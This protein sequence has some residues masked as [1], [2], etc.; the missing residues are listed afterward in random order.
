VISLLSVSFSLG[1]HG[2]V[3]STFRVVPPPLTSPTWK[4]LHRHTRKSVS[5]LTLDPAQL[6][7]FTDGAYLGTPFPRRRQRRGVRS[8]QSCL[9]F[10]NSIRDCVVKSS[11]LFGNSSV[12]NSLLLC[13]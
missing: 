2:M 7:V 13:G 12:L 1:P 10:G 6:T 9:T 3:P 8:G 4:Y 5:L 11:L